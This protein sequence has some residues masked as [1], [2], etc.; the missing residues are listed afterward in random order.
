V[1]EEIL[2][3]PRSYSTKKK[4]EETTRSLPFIGMKPFE[5]DVG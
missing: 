4:P 3:V 2:S 5:R 1:C